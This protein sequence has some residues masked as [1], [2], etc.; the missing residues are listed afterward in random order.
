M[1]KTEQEFYYEYLDK[2]RDFRRNPCLETETKAYEVYKDL[3]K[4]S[5]KQEFMD[6]RIS[7]CWIKHVISGY[8]NQCPWE[9]V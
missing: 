1:T 7:E 8:D 9:E 2:C 3:M 4:E 5:R 6:F